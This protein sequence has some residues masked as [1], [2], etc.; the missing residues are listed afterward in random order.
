MPK[1][2]DSRKATEIREA[3]DVQMT[4]RLQ[5]GE[6][7]ALHLLAQRDGMKAAAML[8]RF[9]REQYRTVFGKEVT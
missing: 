9:I 1:S 5:P 4:F 3:Y 8:R 7:R 6:Q 2:S